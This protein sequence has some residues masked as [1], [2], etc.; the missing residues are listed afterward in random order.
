MAKVLYDLVDKARSGDRGALDALFTETY[1][2]VYYFALKTVKNEDIAADI[3]QDS[4]VTIFKTISSLQE[5]A[6][7]VAWSRQITYRHCLKY[8]GNSRE[9]TVE[10]NEDGTNVFDT[11]AEEKAEFIPNAALDQEDFRNTVMGMIHQL[12]YEQRTALLMYYFDELSVKEIA[13]I[14]DVSEGT[15]KSRLNYG[16]K[17]IK[18]SVED[19]E[20]K[21]GVRLHSF[22]I[23]PLLLWLLLKDKSAC[24]VSAG[25]VK[26]AL[27]STSAAAGSAAAKG[28]VSG[29]A[30]KIAA[31]ITGAAVLVGGGVWVGKSLNKNPTTPPTV[32]TVY[33]E[34]AKPTETL[35]PAT[36][37][38]TTTADGYALTPGTFVGYGEDPHTY[39]HI[40]SNR[41]FTVTVDRYDGQTV[42]GHFRMEYITEETSEIFESDFTGAV[43]SGENGRDDFTVQ[44]E[45]P[46]VIDAIIGEYVQSELRLHY[47]ADT[48]VIVLE[49]YHFLELSKIN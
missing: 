4:F 27:A 12:P 43:V 37:P 49:D 24:S 34:P 20:K 8:L 36:Q 3:T 16:R 33:T 22:A 18:G 44:L 21:T 42:S 32:T 1:N 46:R 7:Y 47:K 38:E 2:D 41:T 5:P 29:L 28:T 13:Q 15:V 17:A 30:V 6:A 9:V 35:P 26:T 11:V 14:Q 39:Y 45:T 19:Y 48:N 23:V 25:A 31:G 40:F 10:D